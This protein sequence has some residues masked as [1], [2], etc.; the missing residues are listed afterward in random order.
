MARQ[1]PSPS[2][3]GR[4]FCL[5]PGGGLRGEGEEIEVVELPLAEAWQMALSGTIVDIKTVLL[6][7]G[8]ML[9]EAMNERQEPPP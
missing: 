6:L 8:A 5:A 1:A 7:Q 9:E 2:A 4:P 3:C